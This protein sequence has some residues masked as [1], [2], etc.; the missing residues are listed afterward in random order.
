MKLILTLIFCACANFAQA[1]IN[2]SSLFLVIDNKDGIQKTETRNIKGEENYILKTSYYKE[3]QNVE[4]LFDNGKNANYYIAYYINQSENWQV[5]FR[6]DYY[7]GEENETYGGYI[8]LL[9]NPMF[10]SFKRKGNVAIFQDAQKQWKIYNRKEFI[11]KIRTNHSQYIYRHL[12]GGKYRDTTRN[13][14]FIVFSSDLEKD[15]IPCY[16]VDVLIS[17]IEEE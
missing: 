3:H 11:N 13:N 14:I 1:Q 16:E 4:L 10:E 2:P 5:S 12:S 6:F 8:L 15:Y 9:S 7:K 17:T